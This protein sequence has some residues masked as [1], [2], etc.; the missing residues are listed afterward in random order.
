MEP[1]KHKVALITGAGKG[2]GFEI[3]RQL[4]L[5][6][7]QVIV[8]GRNKE[9][10]EHAAAQ[11]ESLKVKAAPMLLDVSEYR[12]IQAAYDSISFSLNHLDVLVN[13]AGLLLDGQV[14][15]LKASVEIIETTLHTNAL[16][17]L[18]MTQAFLP[19]LKAGSRVI[20]I[21]SD[22]GQIC[23][24]I[25]TWAPVYCMSKTLLNAITL[26]LAAALSG[27]SVAVNAVCPG[28]VQTDMGG[29]GATRPV[30][31]GAETP[32]WL[33]T[34]APLEVSGKFFRDKKAITW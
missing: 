21:S 9:Q 16:G 29:R 15:L 18:Y 24:G 3:A 20:N 1:F 30:T 6:G 12:S 14:S 25:S 33:A 34:E 31:K 13:N 10:M 26:Q 28:W 27:H 11:L 2:I 7:F 19:L 23:G 5:K 8:A 17:A 22:G 32:V 4:G